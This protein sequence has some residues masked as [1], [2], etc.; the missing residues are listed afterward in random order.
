M[1]RE[2]NLEISP[3][4]ECD[5]EDPIFDWKKASRTF[6]GRIAVPR[7]TRVK[8]EGSAQR[9]ASLE[10]VDERRPSK[11]SHFTLPQSVKLFNTSQK[12]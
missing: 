6:S 11:D 9:L 2:I 12:G 8:N 3:F 1:A 4:L 7:I 5:L 10:K